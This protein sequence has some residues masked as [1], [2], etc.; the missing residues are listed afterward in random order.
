M[1]SA[2]RS[3]SLIRRI[4]VAAG[5]LLG[6]P[7]ALFVVVSPTLGYLFVF[8]PVAL[9]VAALALVMASG[10][11][12]LDDPRPRFRRFLGGLASAALA[13]FV[14]IG[15]WWPER[16]VRRFPIRTEMLWRPSLGMV[17]FLFFSTIAI[18]YWLP[19][20]RLLVRRFG[21]AHDQ[22]H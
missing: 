6:V 22:D 9:G 13:A 12:T 16:R 7:L 4:V 3:S 14:P 2:V 10:A 18:C 15:G 8:A 19:F 21:E 11:G 20:L 5:L 17:L 1:L